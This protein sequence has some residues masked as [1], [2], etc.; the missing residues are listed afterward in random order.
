M[1]INKLIK[2]WNFITKT[3]A[4]E[5]QHLLTG[6]G[7]PGGG[8][9]GWRIAWFLLFPRWT[10]P[11]AVAELFVWSVWLVSTGLS[12]QP[13]SDFLA[14][15]TFLVARPG[16]I[17]MTDDWRGERSYSIFLQ[18]GNSNENDSHK[19]WSN[20]I[21]REE[22]WNIFTI[23]QDLTFFSRHRTAKWVCEDGPWEDWRQC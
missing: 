19:R 10:G 20:Q 3:S 14:F 11:L 23:Y 15:L 8:E 17:K 13:L 6:G 4:V 2:T 18:L 22:L 1:S 12:C 9:P 16:I 5:E 21:R 7:C